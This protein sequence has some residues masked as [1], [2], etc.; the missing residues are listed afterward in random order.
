MTQWL[1]PDPASAGHASSGGNSGRILLRAT[2]RFFSPAFPEEGHPTRLEDTMEALPRYAVEDEYVVQEMILLYK[3]ANA[4]KRI[5]LLSVWQGQSYWRLPFEVAKLAVQDP[6]DSVRYWMAR[7]ASHLD[8]RDWNSQ[9]KERDDTHPERNLEAQLRADPVPLVGAAVFENHHLHPYGPPWGPPGSRGGDELT[10]MS[11]LERLAGMRNPGVP[12]HWAHDVAD[13]ALPMEKRQELILALL[14]NPRFVEYSHSVHARMPADSWLA[15]E[16]DYAKLWDT[17]SSWPYSRAK[18]EFFHRL[19]AP[20]FKKA[21]IYKAS[22]DEDYSVRCAILEGC[23]EKDY[24]AWD[25]LELGTTDTDPHCRELAYSKHPLYKVHEKLKNVLK[26]SDK[27]SILGLYSNPNVTA[28]QL[29]A[30]RRRVGELDLGD[31]VR[32][33]RREPTTADIALG[34]SHELPSKSARYRRYAWEFLLGLV[35][36][37]L[38]LTLL[39]AAHEA[40]RALLGLLIIVCT[41]ALWLEWRWPYHLARVEN[42]AAQ[43]LN[44]LKKLLGAKDLTESEE[45]IF[46]A[47]EHL[48]HLGGRLAI[49][50]IFLVAADLLAIG[51]LILSVL[52]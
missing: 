13:M 6:D 32:W 44:E 45:Q 24:D 30:I 4:Q 50:A 21:E 11:H 38:T 47:A 33:R 20:G 27:A 17:I 25:V 35:G 49:R 5:E 52:Q 19:Y 51:S 40:Q 16:F 39:I 43:R 31:E 48:E 7:N 14:T 23:D 42:H 26:G 46:S 15:I 36:L 18:I 28:A 1:G 10:A 3:S 2:W 37:S 9:T 34:L 22:S 8:Y 12:A 29:E 41:S